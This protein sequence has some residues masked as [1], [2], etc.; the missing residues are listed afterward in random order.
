MTLWSSVPPEAGRIVTVLPA[1]SCVGAVLA[2]RAREGG[3]EAAYDLG[4]DD[5][6]RDDDGTMTCGSC[7][8]QVAGADLAEA[9]VRWTFGTER[10]RTVWA[11]E[12]C[13]RQHARSIEG[14]LD[15]AWW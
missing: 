12:R 9:R 14:K 6:G 3:A 4:V 11:C 1:S 15:S 13:S 2:P 10:G 7:G 8:W 5:G